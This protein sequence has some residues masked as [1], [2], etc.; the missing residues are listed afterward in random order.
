M[1]RLF[2]EKVKEHA[3]LARIFDAVNSIPQSETSKYISDA[4]YREIAITREGIGRYVRNH[5]KNIKRGR[6]IGKEPK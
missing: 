1:N 5:M 3:L 6:Q 4:T 2:R